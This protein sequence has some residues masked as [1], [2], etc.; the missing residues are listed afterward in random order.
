[1]PLSWRLIIVGILKS[2]ISGG[3][4]Q[5][6]N[7][8]L[9]PSNVSS[10]F[11]V[12]SQ[13]LSNKAT[14][15][16]QS[17]IVTEPDTDSI[18]RF[19]DSSPFS[20]SGRYLALLQI[21]GK[22]NSRL[23]KNALAK[24]VVF[25][26]ILGPSTKAVVAQTTAWDSQVGSHVQWGESDHE[27]LYN[28]FL[29][30]NNTFWHGSDFEWSS[31]QRHLRGVVH[32]ILTQ[33]VRFLD[34]PI[35]HVSPN[36]KF[37]VSPDLSKIKFTQLGYGVDVANAVRNRNAPKNDGIRLTNVRTGECRLL[38]S[39]HDLALLG[40]LDSKY[41]PTYGFHA[42]YSSDGEFVMFVI[43]QLHRKRYE[44][45][46]N[47][48]AISLLRDTIHDLIGGPTTRTQH[49]FVM[50]SDGSDPFLL[51]SWGGCTNSAYSA[52][53]HRAVV[54][55]CFDGNHPNWVP[56]SHN[57]TMNL[58]L[59]GD[60]AAFKKNYIGRDT[61]SLKWKVVSLS[62]D[63]AIARRKRKSERGSSVRT[64]HHQSNGSETDK[65]THTGDASPVMTTI[66]PH[67]SGH[68]SVRTGGRYVLMDAYQKERE[69][70]QTLIPH[71][72]GHRNENRS[73]N[74]SGMLS[75]GSVPLRLVNIVTQKEVW[76]LQ[77]INIL[78]VCNSYYEF[79]HL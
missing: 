48:V 32:D 49:L 7:I 21:P 31:K 8:G 17:W 13:Q 79:V 64:K 53:T 70:L 58:A 69:G 42:K 38:N 9:L 40:G 51:L 43:R 78:N 76:L 6:I 46:K 1:M 45:E 34:C 4:S 33:S 59:M 66:Y 67:G 68:P 39:L 74:Y 35:Y 71:H 54:T 26:L 50:R 22:R 41:I 37:A 19:F 23:I 72:V 75:P 29:D 27:L 15:T 25:D 18:H 47:G 44:F 65:E 20:P 62:V 57:I 30:D 73:R 61:F 63:A 55:G 60:N 52:D 12:N 3:S 56:G 5:K 28:T 77:V 11:P 2:I 10:N 24:V 36:G 14:S 16:I